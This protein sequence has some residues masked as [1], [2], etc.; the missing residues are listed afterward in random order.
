MQLYIILFSL[1][2]NLLQ[3][4]FWAKENKSKPND[5]LESFRSTLKTD[6]QVC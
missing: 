5:H 4:F 2:S 3:L 6:S 1:V